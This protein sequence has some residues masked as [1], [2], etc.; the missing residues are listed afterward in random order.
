MQKSQLE[1]EAP[2]CN[3]CGAKTR[4]FGLERHPE[5]AHSDLRTYVCSRCEAVQTETVPLRQVPSISN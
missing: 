1:G 4:L 2:D 5:I 3:R